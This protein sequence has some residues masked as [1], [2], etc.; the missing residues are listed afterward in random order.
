MI[1]LLPV[2]AVLAAVASSARAEFKSLDA[3]LSTYEYPFSVS[4]FETRFKNET[5]KMA[6][7]DVPPSAPAKPNG[8]T[9]VLL[10]GKNFAGIYWE[11]TIRALAAEG[12]RVI[13][14]DQIGFGKSSKPER[15]QFSFQLLASWTQALIEKLGAKPYA[16]VGHS[17]G[18]M[19]A[20]RMALLYP[21]S[22]TRLALVNPIGLE[23]WKTV[24]PYK[25]VDELYR[26][27]LAANEESIRNYQKTAYFG[28]Q[29]KPEYDRGIEALVGWTKH[30]DYPKVAWNAALTAEMIFTQPVYYEFKNLKPRTLLMVGTRDRTAVGK[31]WADP[32]VAET[33]GHYEKLGKQVAKLIPRS[34]LV[35]IPGVGH[36]PQVE[37]FDV[38]WKELSAFLR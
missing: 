18:G 35:E 16:L 27:E 23:D 12:Y 1:R 31:A 11:R 9:V 5:L 32:K 17:M 21:E 24:V 22:V 19:L 34:K 10:H 13:V 7:M 33:L 20:T 37:A 28:G 14:P 30:P 8:K 6:Y 25:P 26:K 36:L 3:E 4:F 15:I 2:F 29:W 38:Y